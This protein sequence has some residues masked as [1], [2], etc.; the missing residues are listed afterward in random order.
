MRLLSPALLFC[1]VAFCQAPPPLQK[2]VVK[3]APLDTVS[4]KAGKAVKVA[5]SLQV[6]SG[7]H[8]N[9]NKPA[10]PYLIPL[11]LT[12]STGPLQS[13]AI[14]FPKPQL[15]NYGFSPKPVSVFT[16]NFEIVTQFK[17]APGAGPG[18]AVIAGKLHY[19]ACNEN[20]CLPPK[21]IDVSL[22][23]EIVQ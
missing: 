15:E 1:T 21:T 12:W 11:R 2:V 3:V 10:D 22:P 16:G 4:V 19:Q 5:L 14:T 23:V 6:D 9:S 7:Y 8:V 17:T 18:P 13:S 20:M